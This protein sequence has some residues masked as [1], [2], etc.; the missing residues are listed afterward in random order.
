MELPF[1]I[2]NKVV[3]HRSAD[4]TRKGRVGSRQLEELKL[5]AC[6]VVWRDL[7][8]PHKSDLCICVYGQF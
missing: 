1:S 2:P 4:G 6:P 3:K 5:P 8:F 7:Q